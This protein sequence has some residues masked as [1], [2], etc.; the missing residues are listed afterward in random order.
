MTDTLPVTCTLGLVGFS[1]SLAHYLIKTDHS[2][3]S[4]YRLLGHLSP[5]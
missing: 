5:T 2:K 3:D 1:K 4:E